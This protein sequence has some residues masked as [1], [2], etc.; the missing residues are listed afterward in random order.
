PGDTLCSV[1][2]CARRPPGCSVIVGCAVTVCAGRRAGC[3][4][5]VL[6]GR[7]GSG[8]WRR[9]QVAGPLLAAAEVATRLRFHSS[10]ARKRGVHGKECHGGERL[11]GRSGFGRG[12]GLVR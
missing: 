9:T 3:S 5:S 6:S 4:R 10:G 12:E 11:H 2:L 8:V 7:Y 1:T